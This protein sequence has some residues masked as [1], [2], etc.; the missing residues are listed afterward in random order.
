MLPHISSLLLAAG[1]LVALAN[2]IGMIHWYTRKRRTS[3]IPM[4]GGVLGFLGCMAHPGV[5]WAWGFLTLGLD[6][7]W[8]SLIGVPRFIEAVWSSIHKRET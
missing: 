3:L 7:W 6:P 4:I 5:H 8:S 1:G 2:W